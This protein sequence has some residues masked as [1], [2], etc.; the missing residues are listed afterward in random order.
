MFFTENNPS[1]RIERASLSGHNRTV[2]IYRGLLRVMALSVDAENNLL[3]WAD[4]ERHTVE[5][6]GYDGNNRRV[7]QRMNGVSITG[8][9]YYNNIVYG[10]SATR[11]R[12]IG[13]ATDTGDIVS[14][15]VTTA[16]DPFS[17]TVYDA[18]VN[19]TYDDPCAT[20]N[21]QQICVNTPSG[22]ECLCG[23]GY[24][25][26]D[27][28]VTCKVNSLFYDKGLVINNATMLFMLDTRFINGA[29][30]RV[31][32]LTITSSIITTF[33]VNAF[34]RMIYFADAKTNSLHELDTSTRR[35]RILASTAPV[36]D[37][38]YDWRADMLWWI[39]PDQS[40]IRTMSLI[41]GRIS[42]IYS[43]LK[44][45]TSLTI[46]AQNGHV[47]WISES[48][49]IQGSLDRMA[50]K[51]V[52]SAL[53]NP[54]HLHFD[55]TSQRLFWLEKE[56]YIKSCKTN[57][58]DVKS[59]VIVF[60]ASDIFVY[61]DFIGW[62]SG[63]QI[64]F[65]KQT[66][67]ASE[68]TF[69]IFPSPKEVAVLDPLL[70][71]DLTDTCEIVNGGCDD[72]CVPM[73]T[74][75]RCECDTGL[76]LQSD[77]KSCTSNVMEENFILVADFSHGR[78]LQIDIV[79]GEMTKLAVD[80]RKCSGV[81]FDTKTSELFYADAVQKNIKSF[82]FP[83]LTPAFVYDT[84]IYSVERMAVDS[85]TGNLY[86]TA[87]TQAQPS[88][89]YI[90]VVHR[91]LALHKT[92]ISGLQSP[93][94]IA[95]YASKGM[96]FWTEI[97]AHARIGKATMD[98]TAVEYIVTSDVIV[99][100]G[101]AVDYDARRLYWTDGEQNRIEHSDL[102]GAN[103]QVLS[104]HPGALMMDLV[105]NGRF[106]YCTAWNRQRV[107]K[108]DKFSGEEL[109]FMADRPELGRLDG[110]V[111]SSNG[112]LDESTVCSTRNGQCSTFC[113]PTPD[114]STCG[115]ED[116]VS[117][118]SDREICAG[119]TSCLTS[120]PNMNLLDCHPYSGQSCLYEC[121]PGYTLSI[122][123][124]LHCDPTG[125]WD[126]DPETL[127]TALVDG[128]A[129]GDQS[130][131]VQ[132]ALVYVYAGV[133]VALLVVLVVAAIVVR[134]LVRGRQIKEPTRLYYENSAY[135]SE[136]NSY[137]GFMTRGNE[138]SCTERAGSG[139]YNTIG[140]M[141]AY[142]EMKSSNTSAA[143]HYDPYINPCADLT[144]DTY[145][146]PCTENTGNTSNPYL[147]AV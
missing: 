28:G 60:N 117:L 103:R 77:F 146:I 48:S 30:G 50:P 106:L 18:S 65:A 34:S 20:K 131:S 7:L 25:L 27:D 3:F 118:E 4:H 63:N 86:F 59:H 143:C 22:P 110:V 79:T 133:G 40:F 58:T 45:P 5:V 6:S 29:G 68:V 84:G 101:L 41:T 33:A 17:V 147:K 104:T 99:P 144:K 121:K 36:T 67:V 43:N 49:I 71:R 81:A 31:P 44:R 129:V 12:L 80:V 21:C 15:I 1:C 24:S 37:L 52:L 64:H 98:G 73:A 135:L 124:T 130:G 82:S 128:N 105:V 140:D 109:P 54:L 112:S 26:D 8:L 116:G 113:F 10:V 56:M 46:D 141:M 102:D 61:K 32:Y 91:Q 2:L 136:G 42:T 92:L 134:R 85:S 47:F 127:C 72:I 55:V 35:Y 114:G 76:Q 96:L 119:A 122:N 123:T 23:E 145:F 9:H 13:L 107:I 111:I 115:C 93:R 108:I 69:N 53:N 88:T 51:T 38:T 97:G 57:G 125:Q 39:E 78:I 89:G 11:R 95:L 132:Q 120:L 75:S 16:G 94:A 126:V 90:G 14:D 62:L 74:G 138:S 19:V 83:K 100:N 70:Q 137:A 66:S 139:D 142:E 87:I